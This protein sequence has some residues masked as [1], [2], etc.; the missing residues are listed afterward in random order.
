MDTSTIIIISTNI[1]IAIGLVTLI[2]NQS[3]KIDKLADEVYKLNS[4]FDRLDD[5]QTATNNRIDKLEVEVKEQKIEFR[6]L[7][8]KFLDLMPKKTVF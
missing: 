7:I 3:K 4:K 5:R 1:T 8:N 2:F 6:E